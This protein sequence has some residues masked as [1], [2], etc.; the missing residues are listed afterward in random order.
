MRLPEMRIFLTGSSGFIGRNLFI[1]LSV[2][3]Y[4]V[5]GYDLNSFNDRHTPLN[6]VVGD[7]NN[8]HDL[9]LSV[10]NFQPEILIHLAARTDLLGTTLDDYKTNVLGVE[11]IC[12]V[13]NNTESIK[14]SI[15]T[16]SQL[17]CKIGYVPENEYEYCP[18]TIYGESKVETEKI[19]RSTLEYKPWTIVRPTTVWGPGMSN[20]YLNFIRKIEKGL[21]FH[22]GSKSLK[23]SYS[24]IGNIIH[25]YSELIQIHHNRVNEKV[26]YLFDNDPLCIRDYANKISLELKVSEPKSIPKPFAIAIAIIGSGLN[27]IKINFPYNLFRYKNITTEY[28]FDY[29]ENNNIFSNLPFSKEEGIKKMIKWYKLHNLQSK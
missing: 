23:K 2:Q 24:Y 13:I 19:V 10:N 28:I 14:Y 27:L 20:H 3:G 21:Y 5:L 25:Q 29:S 11:N 6:Y 4:D 1:S 7:I 18:D 17:V 15:I 16:S 22:T 26:L 12:N 8:L 9:E